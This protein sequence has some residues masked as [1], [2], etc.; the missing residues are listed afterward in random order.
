MSEQ[1]QIIGRTTRIS[2]R[3]TSF[4]ATIYKLGGDDL[5]RSYLAKTAGF[6]FGVDRA[7]EMVAESRQKREQSRQRSA[8]SSTT[9]TWWINFVKLGVRE[10][11]AP[12][13]AEARRDGHHPR[14]RRSKGG[15]RRN[16]PARGAERAWTRHVRSSRKSIQIV[17]KRDGKGAAH[18]HLRLARAPGG[19]GHRELL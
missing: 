17:K 10:I 1:A 5:C 11:A 8:P 19:R 2:T 7:V 14:P 3:R 15:C 4:C 12:E 6:C 16:L 9:A 13:E 18:P